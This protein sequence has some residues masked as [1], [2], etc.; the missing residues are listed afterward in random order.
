[1]HQD[2]HRLGERQYYRR[3]ELNKV[4]RAT[5]APSIVVRSDEKYTHGFSRLVS[6]MQCISVEIPPQFENRPPIHGSLAFP[7][8]P[9]YSRIHRSSSA[10][11]PMQEPLVGLVFEAILICELGQQSEKS[12]RPEW[13]IWCRRMSWIN[14]GTSLHIRTHSNYRGG[15]LNYRCM[16]RYTVTDPP[17]G[18]F[19]HG[20]MTSKMRMKRKERPFPKRGQHSWHKLTP[21]S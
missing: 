4:S 21:Q 19:K 12:A 16:W 3:H 7:T 10:V 20:W 2:F 6:P 17:T 18:H 8:Y 13:I 11:S 9:D 15:I 1:M 14:V 5:R